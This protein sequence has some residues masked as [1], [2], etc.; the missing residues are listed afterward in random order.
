MTV[1][2]P[3]LKRVKLDEQS[4]QVQAFIRSLPLGREGCVLEI[5]GKPL[6]KVVPITD[7]VVDEAKLKAAILAR[8]EESRQNHK[9]WEA[10]NRE[11]WEEIAGMEE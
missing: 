8:R 5:N 3:K 9:E 10:A 2:I 6:L 4:E 11:R 7:V 1:G